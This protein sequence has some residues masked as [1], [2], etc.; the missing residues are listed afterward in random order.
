MKLS[1]DLLALSALAGCALAL[2]VSIASLVHRWRS[3]DRLRHQ[4]LLWLGLAFAMPVLFIPVVATPWARPWMF[5]LVVVPVPIAI[6]V[7]IFQRRLYDVQLVASRTLT[8]VALSAAVAALYALTVAG[9]GAVLDQPGADWLPWLAT[10]VVAVSFTP[11]RNVLQEG[12]NRLANGQWSQPAE[13]LGATARRLA[14][15]VDVTA[16][17]EVL[18]VQIG[19]SLKLGRVEIGDEK[20]R[21]LAEYGHSASPLDERPLS[22]F[23]MPVGMLRWSSD[24]PLRDADRRLLDDVAHQLGGAVH[25]AGLVSTLQDARHRL[26]VSREEERRRL[27]RDLH[28]SL[29]PALASLTLRVD[30][31]RNTWPGLVDPDPQLIELRSAIQ[32]TIFDVRRIV[33]GLRPPPLDELGLAGA[34]EQLAARSEHADDAMVEVRVDPLPR[35]DAAVEVAVFR[36]VQEAQGNARRHSGA[37]RV[38]IEVGSIGDRL[39][40]RVRDDGVGTVRPRR[41]GVGLTSMRE[42]A[43]ELGGSLDIDSS[44][45]YGTVVELQLPLGRQ[46]S[47]TEMHR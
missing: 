41:G 19:E 39:C 9:V 3:G 6:A 34:L 45:G 28:D 12:V 27:R 43:I 15:A 25:A 38:T 29:G 8:Y 32:A 36:V 4:Q 2:V 11:L 16:L 17:L 7:A 37:A 26:V 5:A 46:P 35:L 31:L 14:D 18:V 47:A 44:Q 10:G 42:R 21:V 13:V 33:E 1:A 23:G 40:V 24:R 30:V 20:D 22:A